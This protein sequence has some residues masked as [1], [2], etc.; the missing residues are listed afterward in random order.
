MEIKQIPIKDL[1]PAEYN[2]R[3]ITDDELGQLKISIEKFGIVEPIVVNKDMTVIGGHQRLKAIESLGMETAP[4]F[5]LDLDKKQE[6][7]LNLALNKISGSW[8]EEKL[9][10]LINDIQDEAIGFNEFEVQ[11]YITRY[12]I[13]NDKTDENTYNPDEDEELKKMFE[14][15][16]K[17]AVGLEEPDTLI[18][19]D[20][21]AFYVDTF[22]QYEKIRDTFK[23]T[24]K[25][26]LDVNKLIEKIDAN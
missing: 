8:D 20:R 1:N 12:E 19:K 7:I 15:K 21:L 26:E 9:A 24:R 11:Q 23:T 6:K 4:C 16:E 2:P 18:R 14:R 13:M 17:V 3:F 22:E 25:G 10:T 5:V